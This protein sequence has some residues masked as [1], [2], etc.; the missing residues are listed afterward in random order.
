MS[1]VS[2]TLNVALIAV[3][4]A[5][6]WMLH[7]REAPAADVKDRSDPNIAN[8]ASMETAAAIGPAADESPLAMAVMDRLQRIDARLAALE[9]ATRPPSA[10]AAQTSGAPTDRRTTAE[11]DR[12]LAALLPVRELDHDGWVRWQAS[13]ASMP[14]DERLALSTA[15]SRAVNA[16]KIRLKF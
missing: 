13:L 11:A 1:R 4:L 5:Q 8:A 12:R 16:N 6:A 7:G 10:A 9:Q 3:V 15:F 14:P 2:T